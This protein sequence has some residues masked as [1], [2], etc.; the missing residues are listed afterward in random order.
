[1]TNKW[2]YITGMLVLLF[3]VSLIFRFVKV[4]KML[5]S[6]KNVVAIKRFAPIG[7]FWL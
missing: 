1:M 5:K 6:E 4:R 2:D 7:I 3:L